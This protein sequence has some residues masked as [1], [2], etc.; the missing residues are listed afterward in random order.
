MIPGTLGTRIMLFLHSAF[1]RFIVILSYLLQYIF[2]M[3]VCCNAISFGRQTCR[4][5][6]RGHTRGRS[7]QDFSTFLL[8]CLPKFLLREG[9]SHPRPSSTVK[10]RI[11][12]FNRSP[13]LGHLFYFIFEKNP[14]RVAAPTF[15]LPTEPPGPPAAF[16]AFIHLFESRGRH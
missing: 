1:F 6:S 12:N 4:H 7:P 9:F 8:R 10:C 3:C 2:L 16:L 15:K 13:L 11:S 14:V 5:T